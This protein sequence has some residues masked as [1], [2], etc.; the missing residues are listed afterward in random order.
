MPTNHEG[1]TMKHLAVAI[2]LLTSSITCLAQDLSGLCM[3]SESRFEREPSTTQ[4]ML[5]G[6]ECHNGHDNCS[7]MNNSSIAWNRWTGV[8][9]ALLQSEGAQL[10]AR[11]SGEAGE[12]TCDGTVHDSV[13]AGRYRFAPSVSF[14]QQMDS[15][16]F[17]G[18]TPRKQL[19][20]LM[21]DIN[22]PW[23]K[24]MK[25]AGI[26]E[27][28]TNKLISLR[29]LHVDPDYV[30]AMAAAGYPELRANKLTE[31]KAV[32]VTPEKVREAKTLGFQPTEQELI[33]MS[34]FK[35]DR[36]FVDRMRAKGLNDLT[37]A[38]LIKIKIFKLED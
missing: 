38:R 22:I 33:Q 10:N 25:A 7:E 21:L 32:G 36:P 15:L 24:Q 6:S 19:S 1:D 3:L 5:A 4:I 11:M 18:V 14:A 35:I 23:T 27:M 26:T 17:D 12:L 28:S 37:L 8:S 13:L 30:H 29:A 9:H 34:I 20:F 31:M 16:G 2:L